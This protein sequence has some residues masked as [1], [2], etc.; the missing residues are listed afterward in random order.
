M[1]FTIMQVGS[2]R[3]RSLE[4]R[5]ATCITC[6][7]STCWRVLKERPRSALAGRALSQKRALTLENTTLKYVAGDKNR[8]KKRSSPLKTHD[9]V[10]IS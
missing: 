3:R 1:E 10:A 7:I 4:A 8:S 6:L 2:M 9:M 5:T